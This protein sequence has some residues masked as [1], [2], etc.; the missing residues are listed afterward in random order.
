M[1]LT[2]LFL[3]SIGVVL[4]LVV[5]NLEKK[6]KGFKNV[7]RPIVKALFLVSLIVMIIGFTMAYLDVFRLG[8]YILIPILAVFLVRKTFIYFQAKN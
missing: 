6:N 8:V 7:S 5:W 3:F 1:F 2:Y 4:G